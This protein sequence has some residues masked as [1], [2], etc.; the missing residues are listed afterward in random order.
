MADTTIGGL[1]RGTPNK[2]S[3]VIPYSDGSSTYK[4]SPSGIVAASP[5]SIIQVQFFQYTSSGIFTGTAYQDV[6]GVSITPTSLNS[7]ILVTASLLCTADSWNP[8]PGYMAIRKGSTILTFQRANNWA[9][10]AG[11]TNSNPFNVHLQFLD[12]PNSISQITY[13]VSVGAAGAGYSVAVNRTIGG[14]TGYGFSTI[15]AME[16]A[17]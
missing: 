16:I 13:N 12:S 9:G 1:S 7:K 3:A 17:G 15:S 14:S 2:N 8:G 5:G 10:S 6:Y 4:T 11:D